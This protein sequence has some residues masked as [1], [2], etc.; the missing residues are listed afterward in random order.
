MY[1]FSLFY[2]ENASFYTYNHVTITTQN[3]RTFEGRVERGVLER[4]AVLRIK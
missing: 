4:K 1:L 3:S 2:A